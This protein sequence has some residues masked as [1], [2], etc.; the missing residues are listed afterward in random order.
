MYCTHSPEFSIDCAFTW[1]LRHRTV[2]KS[3]HSAPQVPPEALGQPTYLSVFN[4]F[5]VMR[6]PCHSQVLS[7]LT[8]PI[9][10]S[11]S[12]VCLPQ[13]FQLFHTRRQS[14]SQPQLHVVFHR[15]P[16]PQ[17]ALQGA[18]CWI[19]EAPILILFYNS[20]FLSFANS[21]LQIL[22]FAHF[23]IPFYKKNYF[24][25][26][27]SFS[28]IINETVPCYVLEKCHIHLK[29]VSVQNYQLQNQKFCS[30]CCIFIW[31]VNENIN[32]SNGKNHIVV[33][34]WCCQETWPV[35]CGY[36]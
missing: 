35:D 8:K 18:L 30:D 15:K 24:S 2:L 32:K 36:S 12:H 17:T 16:F 9:T 1:M 27:H 19:S 34:Q 5:L 6:E 20:D 14:Y 11:A 25:S 7:L 22:N 23:L 28:L 10:E 31:N 26:V 13:L 33:S 29:W 21:D 4:V 3:V